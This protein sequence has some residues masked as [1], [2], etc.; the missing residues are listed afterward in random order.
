M[1]GRLVPPGRAPP[2]VRPRQ[3]AD[4][5]DQR[6]PPGSTKTGPPRQEGTSSKEPRRP[7][8]VVR[9]PR[10][11]SDR[12]CRPRWAGTVGSGQPQ[13]KGRGSPGSAAGSVGGVEGVYDGLG[14]SSAVAH[15]V[16]VGPG[17]LLHGTGVG[18]DPGTGRASTGAL[19]RATSLDVSSDGG[20]RWS[21]PR[22]GEVAGPSRPLLGIGPLLRT[23]WPLALPRVAAAA[24]VPWWVK[25]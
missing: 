20:V 16:A 9:G 1:L 10:A 17:P 14:D 7:V 3:G 11:G 19:D 2:P 5:R 24:S 18:R 15:R 13:V 6:A 12:A 23:N 22:A 8:G 4:R 21:G 25:L